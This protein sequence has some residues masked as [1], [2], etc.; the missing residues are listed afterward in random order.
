M[1]K[2]IAILLFY[3]SISVSAQ[4]S[5]TAG[6][7]FFVLTSFK[8]GRDKVQSKPPFAW[9]YYEAQ[10]IAAP[11]V[12]VSYTKFKKNGLGLGFN[13]GLSFYGT[14]A[15]TD[16]S[17]TDELYSEITFRMI[18][19]PLT[20]RVSADLTRLIEQSFYLEAGI[21]SSWQVKYQLKELASIKELDQNGDVVGETL[22]ESDQQL[23]NAPFCRIMPMWGFGV[24]VRRLQIGLT[25]AFSI[26]D[27][28]KPLTTNDVPAQYSMYEIKHSEKGKL[29][30]S[31]FSIFV[32]FR[33]TQH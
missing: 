16:Y 4:W 24:R 1:K 11:S 6:T 26:S 29:K 32:G 9:T 21:M 20:F 2:L 22:Y 10:N 5:V 3:V 33:L 31:Y 13:T 28:Y 7:D 27:W 14:K 18:N 8:N 12:N 25:N 15:T 30:F 19:A 17:G 23:V